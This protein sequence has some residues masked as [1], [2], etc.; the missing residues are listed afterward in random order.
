MKR[1]RPPAAA[2]HELAADSASES[3]DAHRK[4]RY[5]TIAVRVTGGRPL[6]RRMPGWRRDLEISQRGSGSQP[7]QVL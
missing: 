4:G 5:R 6:V 1:P 7:E 3:C 2:S